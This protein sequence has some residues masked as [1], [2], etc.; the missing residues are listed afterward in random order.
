[1]GGHVFP[2]HNAELRIGDLLQGPVAGGAGLRS[3]ASGDPKEVWRRG[4]YWMGV[5]IGTRAFGYAF[6]PSLSISLL[7]SFL[8]LLLL[9]RNGASRHH[10]EV[11]WLEGLS[12]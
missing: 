6:P 4:S 8:L 10:R 5:W 9:V 3:G 2:F 12:N 11:L 7:V 1:M